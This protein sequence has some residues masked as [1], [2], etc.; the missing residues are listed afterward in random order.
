MGTAIFKIVDTVKTGIV[1]FKDR[2]LDAGGQLITG[3]WNGI[4]G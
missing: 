2:M 1:D 4:N 3:L